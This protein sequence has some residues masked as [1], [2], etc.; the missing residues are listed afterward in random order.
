MRAILLTTL[1]VLAATACGAAA[2]TVPRDRAGPAAATS[3][4]AG[5]PLA[6]DDPHRKP[7]NALARPIIAGPIDDRRAPVLLYLHGGGW[8]VTGQRAL[9]ENRLTIRRWAS[10]GIAVWGADYRRDRLSLPDAKAAYRALR[11]RVGRRRSICVMGESSG[12]ALALLIA[13][14]FPRIRCVLTYATIGDLRLLRSGP[15]AIEAREWLLPFGGYE[16]WD[17]ATNAS[18]IRQPVVLVHHVA[19][20]TVPVRHSRVMAQRLRSAQLIELRSYARSDAVRTTHGEKT[21]P[22][23]SAR[24]STVALRVVR[25]ASR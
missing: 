24:A 12:G 11:R 6:G 10:R 5:S 13:A 14:E 3:T 15:L 1:A 20:T 9:D 8:V 2:G 21:S 18:R 22:S 7:G 16:R 4:P 25:Q 17:P 23:S 19:D